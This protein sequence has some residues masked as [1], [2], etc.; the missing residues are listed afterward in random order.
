[1]EGGRGMTSEKQYIRDRQ[2]WARGLVI[3]AWRRVEFLADNTF[4]TD[5]MR[6]KADDL[7]RDACALA[8]EWGLDPQAVLEAD[9]RARKSAA[10]G[11]D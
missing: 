11:L 5:E 9:E 7:L 2:A 10:K 3:K 1:V 8:E 4:V 6:D